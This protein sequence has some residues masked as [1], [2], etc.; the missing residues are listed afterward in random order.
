[1][2][3]HG[4]LQLILDDR[5][6]FA[7]DQFL[8]QGG[9]VIIAASPFHVTVDATIEGQQQNTGLDEW[10]RHNGV[11]IEQRFVLDPQNT[12]LLAPVERRVGG[13]TLREIRSLPYPHL[14]DI[15]ESGLNQDNP[16]TASLEQITLSWPSPL[17]IDSDKNS[18]RS[19][20][21]LL[22]SS[23]RSWTSS[24]T[25]LTPNYR[26]Y[27]DDGF[28]VSGERKQR[29]LAAAIE[30]AFTSFYRGKDSPLLQE[31]GDDA[32]D[33]SAAAAD[34]AEDKDKKEAQP[35]ITSVIE[36]SPNS[37][38]LIV[39]GSSSFVSDIAIDF[40]SQSFNTN[41]EQQQA[42]LENA[43]DWSLE[44]RNLL[45]LRGRNQYA[46]TLPPLSEDE[47]KLW[48][49]T[50]YGFAALGLGLIWLWRRRTMAKDR[51]RHAAIIAEI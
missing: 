41:Y 7:V 42:F 23:S 20:H 15:R 22:H 17:R 4:Q 21:E 1:M 19:V 16:I 26:R 34:D 12:P 45:A 10:L 3:G 25:D 44:D 51:A 38:R 37:A 6:R 32:A 29:L 39:V 49:Y 48:E 24:A 8:M 30:G 50:N 47:Q 18:E 46:R 5:Q 2:G 9:S 13:L 28:A 27:P 40:I 43:I 31:E 11:S 14:P 33:A 35:T 36:R